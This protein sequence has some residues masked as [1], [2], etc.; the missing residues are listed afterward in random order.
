MTL[1]QALFPALERPEGRRVVIDV[2]DVL[3]GLILSGRLQPGTVLSQV[4]V[5]RVLKVSRTPVREALRMLQ[6]AGLVSAEPNYRCRVLGFDPDDIETLYVK[7]ITLEALGVAITT[8]RMT[9]GLA[10]ELQATVEAMEGDG[11]HAS[12][13]LWVA[14]HRDFHAQIVS[15]ARAPFAADLRA[16]ELRSWRYQS[17][18]KGEHSPGWWQRGEIEHRQIV[19]A[20]TAKDAGRAAELAA[21][22][23]ARTALELLAALAPAHDTTALRIS[24]GFATGTA[25]LP[26]PASEPRRRRPAPS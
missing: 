4:E 8:A 21:R 13:D 26:A 18:Y 6:E 12:F 25:T 22:H 15:G 24:L 9:Q 7:R 20:M 2:H 3:S 1:D 10:A 5:A 23:L 17:A 19:Q 14:L 11:A 16:L